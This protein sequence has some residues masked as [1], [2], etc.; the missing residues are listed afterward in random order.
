MRNCPMHHEDEFVPIPA[1]V[2]EVANAGCGAYAETY[3][4]DAIFDGDVRLKSE[5]GALWRWSESRP[6]ARCASG[7]LNSN[8]NLFA[9]D[10]HKP[11][12]QPSGPSPRRQLMSDPGLLIERLPALRFIRG[13]LGVTLI[14]IDLAPAEPEASESARPFNR[15]GRPPDW[16]W[17]RAKG[18][19]FAH[20]ESSFS[21]NLVSVEDVAD[22]MVAV[23]NKDPGKGGEE[24]RRCDAMPHAAASWEALKRDFDA[25]PTRLKRAPAN[26]RR[27]AK[28]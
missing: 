1:L 8:C 13:T 10:W 2:A 4:G 14:G 15:G 6:A 17:D 27:T 7:V 18:K 19:A 20:Y 24:A 28:K 12:V 11:S 23:L 16:D 3:V 5:S 25:A 22:F 9:P 26:Q 21:P